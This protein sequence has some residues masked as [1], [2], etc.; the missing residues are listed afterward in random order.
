MKKLFIALVVLT[1]VTLAALKGSLWYLTQQFV[2]N[3]II[4][5]K[6][7]V[8]ISY[9]DIET[10][11]TGR[12]RVNKLKVF[13]PSL[14]ESIHIESMQFVAPNLFSLMTLDSQFK[15]Q[16]I[17]ES[18]SLIVRGISLNLNGN[19][20]KL[21]D[22]PDA[23]P[24][25]IEI[26]STLACGDVYRIGREAL[27]QMGYEKLVSDLFLSYQFKPN[28]KTLSYSIQYNIQDMAQFNISGDL[29]GVSSLDS[30]KQQTVQAGK[31]V[32]DITDESYIERKNH[33]CANKEH[34]QVAQYINKHSKQVKEYLASFGITP[35]DGLLNAYK[36][37]LEKPGTITFESDLSQLNGLQEIQTFMPN[38]LI[39]FIRL[40]L[41]VNGKRINEISIDIDKD[42][43]IEVTTNKEI[44]L[45]TPDQIEKKQ[46]IIIKKYRPVSITNLKNFNAYRVK[47]E[48]RKGKHYKGTLNASDPQTYEIISRMRSGNISY[49]IDIGDIKSAQVFF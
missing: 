28:K 22:N 1:A 31:L 13:I 46:A 30:F 41:Y 27:L 49:H 4:Q 43:L 8:Q 3:Q 19:I 6:P 48:T 21:M 24:T 7:Y 14:N 25:Q 5:A 23:E 9:K 12:A 18:L 34:L 37:V 38:D 44:E 39:Q 40:Q 11:L 2:D 35:E 33:F 29:S 42:K 16:E 45:E 17:P 20:M 10:S 15:N 36:T 26:F 47:I 32:L